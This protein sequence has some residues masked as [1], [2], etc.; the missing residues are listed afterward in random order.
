MRRLVL[1]NPVSF[2]DPAKKGVPPWG[3]ADFIV[4]QA[5]ANPDLLS[6]V[7]NCNRVLGL[8]PR[9]KPLCG[10]NQAGKEI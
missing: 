8:L 5:L 7:E 4:E 9:F 3:L 10:P 6:S 2:S 1:P